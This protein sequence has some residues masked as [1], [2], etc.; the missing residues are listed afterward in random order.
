MSTTSINNFLGRVPKLAAHNWNAYA[1]AM[2]HLFRLTGSLAIVEGKQTRPTSSSTTITDEQAAWD[3]KSGAAFAYIFFTVDPGF[4]YLIDDATSA[5]EAWTKLK[6][7]FQ[8]DT[9]SHRVSLRTQMW[10]SPHDISKPVTAYIHAVTSAAA[11]LAAMN[12]KYKPS[13]EEIR[14]AVL[15]GL[16]TTFATTRAIL[17]AR[18]PEPTLAEITSDLVEAEKQRSMPSMA[19]GIPA[20][21]DTQ[22]F[23]DLLFTRSSGQRTGQ[24]RGKWGNP[25]RDPTACDRCGEIGHTARNCFASM[26]QSRKHQIRREASARR[27]VAD[28]PEEDLEYLPTEE[29][30]AAM[31]V[32]DDFPRI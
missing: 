28:Q 29:E 25:S 7:H 18:R 5:T 1:T 22:P 19:E 30:F 15:S 4:Q 9:F 17:T 2:A 3:T 23:E 13:D 32:N 24:S 8:T 26:P 21:S 12:A 20:D 6:G 27:V 10:R 11:Q 14:D 16:D 31:Q